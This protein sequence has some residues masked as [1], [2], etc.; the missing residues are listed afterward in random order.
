LD[1]QFVFIPLSPEISQSISIQ[2]NASGKSQTAVNTENLPQI[3]SASSK[4]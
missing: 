2:T 3:L 1:K 4:I